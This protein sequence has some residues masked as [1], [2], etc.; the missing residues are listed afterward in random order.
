M[1]EFVSLSGLAGGALIGISAAMLLLFNG[2]IAGMTGLM[3]R[4]A[5]RTGGDGRRSAQAFLVSALVAPLLV[6]TIVAW[7]A[8]EITQSVPALIA[9]GVIVGIGV[10]LSNGCTSGHGICGVSRLSLRSVIATIAFMATSA[11]TVTLLR[12][13]LDQSLGGWL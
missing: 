6:G 13:G 3:A 5:R 2:Q 10:T 11:A 9:S 4:A 12:H 7:E 8:V 1:H